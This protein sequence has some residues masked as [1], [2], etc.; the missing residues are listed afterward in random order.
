MTFNP[1]AYAILEKVSNE[2]GISLSQANAICLE[3]LNE[4]AKANELPK[5]KLSPKVNFIYTILKN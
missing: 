1:D 4:I 2:L 3:S 5:K